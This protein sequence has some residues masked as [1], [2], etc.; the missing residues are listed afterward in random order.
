M[1]QLIVVSSGIPKL[2]NLPRRL[3]PELE[4]AVRETAFYIEKEAKLACP[5]DTGAL[6]AS[7]YTV[8]KS[9]SG[10]NQ[11]KTN[12][13]TRRASGSKKTAGRPT[14]PEELS[15]EVRQPGAYTAIVAVG[16]AYGVYV[17][18]GT[19]RMAARPYLSTAAVRGKA[20]LDKRV[21]E[22][23]KRAGKDS[24]FK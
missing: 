2:R 11:S 6:R 21:K 7:I 19:S 16:M 12:A 23:I 18:Y 1:I 9:S 3:G 13:V 17:E 14:G 22:A 5:V 4:Q 15:P 8:T 10:Y 20:F 24:G